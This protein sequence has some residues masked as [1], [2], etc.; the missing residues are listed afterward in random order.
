MSD[1]PSDTPRTDLPVLTVR[2]DGLFLTVLEQCRSALVAQPD[3]AALAEADSYA[4]YVRQFV[5]RIDA[6]SRRLASTLN[7]EHSL[8]QLA[9]ELR[10][11]EARRGAAMQPYLEFEGAAGQ[12]SGSWPALMNRL[13]NHIAGELEALRDARLRLE[14]R[15]AELINQHA[16]TRVRIV[17]RGGAE[18]R[19]HFSRG[20]RDAAQKG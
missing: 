16:G 8:T 9:N 13:R 10:Q 5:Q 2:F 14:L 1:I 7:D 17:L 3:R 12:A 19:V 4:A 6:E 18:V 20:A 11:I 15:R